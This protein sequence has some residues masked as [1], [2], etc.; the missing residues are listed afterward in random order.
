M[1]KAVYIFED[2]FLKLWRFIVRLKS[3]EC[4][5]LQKIHFCQV[6]VGPQLAHRCTRITLREVA[7]AP[8]LRVK[9]Q[10][11]YFCQVPVGPQLAHCCTRITLQ[12]VAKAPAL[13]VMCVRVSDLSQMSVSEALD[14]RKSTS[15]EVKN[16]DVLTKK[17]MCLDPR[18]ATTP[19]S[20]M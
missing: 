4:P 11:A 16:V 8:A 5:K 14:G 18:P 20:E 1:T 19:K 3:C 10:K 7:K 17:S 15:I 6:L 9:L 13:R 12:E 2:F